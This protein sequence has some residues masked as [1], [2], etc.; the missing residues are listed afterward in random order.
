MSKNKKEDAVEQEMVPDSA[1]A[2]EIVASA[3]TVSE[4]AEPDCATEPKPV[5]ALYKVTDPRGLNLRYDAGREHPV[6]RVLPAGS[7]VEARGEAVLVDGVSWL[8]VQDGWVDAA[9]LAPV[10]AED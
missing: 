1:E 9:Y 5:G 7:V 8:P 2:A 10:T 4:T 6:L 3:E